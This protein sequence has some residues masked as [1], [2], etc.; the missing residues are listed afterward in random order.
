MQIHRARDVVGGVL[1]IELPEE[2]E[3]FLCM[4]QRHA[5][6]RSRTPHERL[7][8]RLAD[9][10]ARWRAPFPVAR[11]ARRAADDR[12]RC[13]RAVARR[14]PVRFAPQA[15]LPAT[16]G[17]HR[18]QEHHR[19]RH[20]DTEHLAPKIGEAQADRRQRRYWRIGI[21]TG[22]TARRERFIVRNG[23][24]WRSSLPLI[25]SG[26]ASSTTTPTWHQMRRQIRGGMLARGCGEVTG[27]V[28]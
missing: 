10:D 2:P 19:H 16:N 13:A 21:C 20:G 26:N 4:R 22:L 24:V 15:S 6:L 9:Q 3:P 5:G 23:S 11:R 8:L 18:E 28:V 17:P 12:R 27:V 25:V 7:P 14:R 1:R